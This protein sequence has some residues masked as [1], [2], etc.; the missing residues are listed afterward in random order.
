MAIRIRELS[1][2]ERDGLHKAQR[3]RDAV[4]Y[5]RARVLLLSADGWLAPAIAQAVGVHV[6]TVRGIIKAFNAH[7]LESLPARRPPGRPP[8]LQEAI[9]DT[10]LA[11][12]R[13]RPSQYGYEMQRWTL[14]AL[15]ETIVRMGLVPQLSHESV[16]KVLRQLGYSWKRAK[17]WMDSPDPKYEEKKGC[18]RS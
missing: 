14:H 16:R 13:Q 8:R 3:S 7:G 11:L 17:R 6:R 12:V 18:A 9:G 5:R 15:A 1:E 4:T 10:L 2:W